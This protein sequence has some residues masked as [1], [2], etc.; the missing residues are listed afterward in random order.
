MGVHPF[1]WFLQVC[2]YRELQKHEGLD[3]EEPIHAAQDQQF[4]S[5]KFSP[6]DKIARYRRVN[7]EWCWFLPSK[8]S[9]SAHQ[10]APKGLAGEEEQSWPAMLKSPFL[11]PCK[12][13]SSSMFDAHSWLLRKRS[14]CF[15]F[16]TDDKAIWTGLQGEGRKDGVQGSDLSEE[17]PDDPGGSISFPVC[18][19]KKT[20]LSH[21]KKSESLHWRITEMPTP[22]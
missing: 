2:A 16:I 5:G 8:F 13:F 18:Y 19:L 6:A 3:T 11:Q 7:L 20:S 22:F 14:W 12:G 9:D 4:C 15:V 1:F 21:Q 17:L 10:W